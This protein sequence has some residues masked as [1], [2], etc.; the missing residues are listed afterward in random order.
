L[1]LTSYWTATVNSRAQ[2]FS[3]GLFFAFRRLNFAQGFLPYFLTPLNHLSNA[4]LQIYKLLPCF[5]NF[6]VKMLWFYAVRHVANISGCGQFDEEYITAMSGK[7]LLEVDLQIAKLREQ[8]AAGKASLDT[9]LELDT[10][11]QERAALIAKIATS[12]EPE[13]TN[14]L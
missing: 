1:C 5:F 9:G 8:M 11:L 6:R 3:R 10:L 14:R 4:V 13:L 12:K 2:K 7:P